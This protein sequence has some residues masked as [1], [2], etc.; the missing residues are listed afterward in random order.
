VTSALTRSLIAVG[1][2]AAPNTLD[3]GFEVT[4]DGRV[5]ARFPAIQGATVNQRLIDE[6]RGY[7]EAFIAAVER[8]R[9]GRAA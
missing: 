8:S 3:M 5:I 9:Q 7:A 6:A 2:P 1:L 4:L